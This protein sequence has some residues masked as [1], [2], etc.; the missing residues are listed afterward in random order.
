MVFAYARG[1]QIEMG[2]RY[3]KSE[4]SLGSPQLWTLERRPKFLTLWRC[5]R[6]SC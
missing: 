4:L 1:W 2:S 5:G 3:N 6:L